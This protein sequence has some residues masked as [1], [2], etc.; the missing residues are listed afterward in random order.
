MKK[1]AVDLA[2]KKLGEKAA[3]IRRAADE[4]IVISKKV[5]TLE[6]LVALLG[7][8]VLGMF[9]SPRKKVSYKIASENHDIGGGEFSVNKPGGTDD[10]DVDDD[11]FDDDD[12][13]DFDTDDNGKNGKFIKL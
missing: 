4:E 6:I 5:Q 12:D 8:I 10:D 11:D 3:D 7:G 13:D 2:A 1:I 9:L